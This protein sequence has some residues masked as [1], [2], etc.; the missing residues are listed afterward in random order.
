MAKKKSKAKPKPAAPPIRVKS[1]KKQLDQTRKAIRKIKAPI[2]SINRKIKNAPSAYY[3]RKYKKEKK[4]YEASIKSNLSGLID[5]RSDLTKKYKHFEKNQ[6]ARSSKKRQISSLEKKI[7]DA[8]DNK[9]IKS[10][11][12]LRY[13][14]IKNLREL[15]KLHK[16]MGV[17]LEEYNEDEIIEEEQDGG[18]GFE[19]DPFSPYAVWEAIK[20]LHEDLANGEFK[21]FIVNG[22][23]FSAENEDE[24][25]VEGSEFWVVI[26]KRKGGTPLVNRFV[27]FKTKTVKYKSVKFST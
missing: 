1:P 16:E 4:A 24:I 20:K 3:A 25:L 18:P 10:A 6:A 5:K 9:D 23:R 19:I 2:Y 12:K 22:K 8:I 15:D 13:L 27:N 7:R 11:E 26:K 14:L 21:Y 17:E